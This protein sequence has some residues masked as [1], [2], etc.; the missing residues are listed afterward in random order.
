MAKLGAIS[1]LEFFCR[2][3]LTERMANDFS[4]EE[5]EIDSCPDGCCGQDGVR[6][7]AKCSSCGRW[8]ALWEASTEAEIDR[9]VPR[10]VA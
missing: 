2:F 9:A 10:E 8:T 4:L 1:S 6:F 7:F 3:C 5:E